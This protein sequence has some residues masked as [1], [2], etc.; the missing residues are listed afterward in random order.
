QGAQPP[1][2]RLDPG[3]AAALDHLEPTQPVGVA[4]PLEIVEARELGLAD[5]HDQL[6]GLRMRDAMGIAERPQLGGTANAESGFERTRLVIDPRVNHTAVVPA[7]VGGNLR[8]LFEHEDSSAG[9]AVDDLP[10]GRQADQAGAD[11]CQVDVVREGQLP[12]ARRRRASENMVSTRSTT[13]KRL[14]SATQRIKSMPPEPITVGAMLRIFSPASGPSLATS[15]G[16]KPDPGGPVGDDGLRAVT[17][18]EE[19]GCVFAE[20]PTAGPWVDA[21]GV[22][23]GVAPCVAAGGGDES[24]AGGGVGADVGR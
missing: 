9:L 10:C 4:S 16:W 20:E 2:G 12:A 18:P 7:L 19:P 13:Q 5:R 11:H 21:A 14:P 17:L 8:F 3:N 6:A 22:G 24:G 23:A 1:G 15:A